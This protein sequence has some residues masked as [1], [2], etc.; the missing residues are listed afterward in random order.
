[1]GSMKRWPAMIALV[2]AGLGS[3]ALAQSLGDTAAAGQAALASGSGEQTYREI[4]A[5]CHMADA[6]GSSIGANAPALAKNPHLEDSD[7]VITRVLRGK[8]GMPSFADILSVEQVADVIGYVRSH[9]GNSY[10]KPVSHADVKRLMP[11][12]DGE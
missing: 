10:T 6:Q 12:K 1:M 3:P 2:L 5:A 4:C 11:P 7:F 8:G 9:F